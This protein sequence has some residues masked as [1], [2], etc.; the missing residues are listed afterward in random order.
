MQERVRI[1]S[2]PGPQSEVRPVARPVIPRAYGNDPEID[3]SAILKEVLGTGQ[4]GGWTGT[5]RRRA[6]LVAVLA[7]YGVECVDRE[8]GI[9]ARTSFYA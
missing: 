4:S 3:V 7:R 8:R 1:E 5:S 2:A 6:V 9:W